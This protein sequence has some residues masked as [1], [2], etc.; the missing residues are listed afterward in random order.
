MADDDIHK[1][2]GDLFGDFFGGKSAG[3]PRGADLRI[4]LDLE[5]VEM[6][7]GCVREVELNRGH[8]C[9]GCA[10]SRYQPGAVI[11]D[12]SSCGGTGISNR[13]QGQFF[14]A[15]QCEACSGRGKLGTPCGRCRG[16]GV[17]RRTEK[18][19][20][21]VPAGVA[22]GQTLRMK[23]QGEAIAGGEPGHLYV[24][25]S[26]RRH[27]RLVRR[28]DDLH[29]DATISPALAATGGT[30]TVPDLRGER[31]VTVPANS[32]DGDRITVRGFGAQILG[33]PETPLPITADGPYR[34]PDLSG[35]GDLIVTLRVAK[36]GWFKKLFAR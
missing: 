15:T 29:V 14:F 34:A 6:V 22:A 9:G 33:M 25:M 19:Q 5:L 13:P 28:D 10:G 17:V 18:L 12:C 35:R 4:D 20:I 36:S 26:Q 8:V 30:I 3:P 16:D 23:G 7:D 32:K 31:E 24:V 1:A 11:T 21:T 2:F 27:D